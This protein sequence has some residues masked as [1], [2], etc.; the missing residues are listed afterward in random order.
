VR[1]GEKVLNPDYLLPPKVLIGSS[2]KFRQSDF[3]AGEPELLRADY[4]L[5]VDIL[6]LLL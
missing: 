6:L 5:D 3:G 1:S 2:S 4:F